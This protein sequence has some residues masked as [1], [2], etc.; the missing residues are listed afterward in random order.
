MIFRRLF[1]AVL[2]LPEAVYF[3]GVE[4]MPEIRIGDRITLSAKPKLDDGQPATVE[5]MTWETGDESILELTSV[6]PDGT[7]LFTAIAQGDVEVSVEADADMGTGVTSIRSGFKIT[8]KEPQATGID[9][10]VVSVAPPEIAPPIQKRDLL[11]G[12]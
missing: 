7:A 2:G 6:N 4:I 10:A 9:I 8:V 3:H 5:S 11:G 1:R 12:K